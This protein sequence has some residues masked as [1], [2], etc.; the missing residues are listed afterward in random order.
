M[1]TLNGLPTAHFKCWW[2]TRCRSRM[3]HLNNRFTFVTSGSYFFLISFFEMPH[4]PLCLTY[5]HLRVCFFLFLL[6]ESLGI[7]MY[8]YCIKFLTIVMFY[9]LLTIHYNVWAKNKQKFV[10]EFFFLIEF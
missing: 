4:L 8:E 1:S 3:S 5:F 9:R 2:G 10:W 6:E 7:M